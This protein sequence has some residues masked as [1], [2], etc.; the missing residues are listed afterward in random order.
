M[1][2][3]AGLTFVALLIAIIIHTF[4]YNREYYIPVEEVEKAEAKFTA[5]QNEVLV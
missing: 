2:L 3:I 1:W 4:N 5:K